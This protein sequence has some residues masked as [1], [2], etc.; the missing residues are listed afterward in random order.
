ML[1]IGPDVG[2]DPDFEK[3]NEKCADVLL[4]AREAVQGGQS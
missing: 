4:K 2:E 1:Q 3:A